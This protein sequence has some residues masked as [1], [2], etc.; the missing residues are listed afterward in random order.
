MFCGLA[1]YYRH[2]MKQRGKQPHA[3]D[4]R[5]DASVELLLT[6]LAGIGCN[7][8]QALLCPSG[9]LPPPKLKGLICTSPRLGLNE[10]RTTHFPSCSQQLSFLYL[11]N[12]AE[13]LA[14]L[15]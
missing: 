3:A 13:K 5:A 7:E 9:G 1:S 12:E 14:G 11:T 10:Y 6:K 4:V 8:T 2:I 15:S